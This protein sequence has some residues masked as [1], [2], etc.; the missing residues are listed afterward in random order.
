MNWSLQT[1]ASWPTQRKNKKGSESSISSNSSCTK[2]SPKNYPISLNS[3][4]KRR[5]WMPKN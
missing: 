5:K 1:T 4:M 3:K 2:K